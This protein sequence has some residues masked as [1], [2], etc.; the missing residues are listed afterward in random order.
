MRDMHTRMI[1]D[2]EDAFPN[3]CVHYTCFETYSLR[4][5]FAYLREKE[6]YLQD[7]I[8]KHDGTEHGKHLTIRLEEV[9]AHL[10]FM[11]HNLR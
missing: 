3:S 4:Q 9:E 11:A 10:I 5:M 2:S 1:F 7:D 6:M 8:K